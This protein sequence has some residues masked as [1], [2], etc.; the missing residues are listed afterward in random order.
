MRPFAE[1]LGVIPDEFKAWQAVIGSGDKCLLL[2]EGEIDKQYIEFLREKFHA[3]FPLQPYVK[4]L[5]YGGTGNLKNATVVSFVKQ[6]VPKIFVTFD[7]DA[8]GDVQRHLEQIGLEEKKDFVAVGKN[9]GGQKAIEGLLPEKVLQAVFGREVQLVRTAAES[10]T[11]EEQKSARNL[12]KRKLLE[13]FIAH[14]DYS[15]D[16]L[17]D[18]ETLGKL[19]AKALS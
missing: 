7:L 18:F 5:S 2:V 14:D 15:D 16:E 10:G 19:I 6:I 1:H 13:E 4:V 11:G 9:R 12:L 17:K 8:K 3:K